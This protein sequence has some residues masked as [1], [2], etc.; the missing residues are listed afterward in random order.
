MVVLPSEF[1]ATRYS[2]YFW[3]TK[4]E[5]LYSIKVSGELKK[6]KFYPERK[7][8]YQGRLCK[9]APGYRISIDGQ[10]Q[11][12]QLAYLKS[13]KSTAKHQVVK[14]REQQSFNF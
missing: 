12:L 9:S 1:V 8:F 7:F 10:R 13:L 11:T 4:D 14:Y 2:G 6:L 3:N 5:T